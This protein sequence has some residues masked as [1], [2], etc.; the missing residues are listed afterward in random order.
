MIEIGGFVEDLGGIGEDEEA[1]SEAFGDPEELEGVGVEVEAGPFAEVGG[2]WAEVY[3]DVPDMAGED[4]DELSL[5]L[6]ELIME[7]AEDAFGGERLVILKKLGGKTGGREGGLVVNFCKPA[8]TI[9]ETVG[10]N[11]FYVRKRCG[12]N[13]HPNSL[14]GER[15]RVPQWANQ[16]P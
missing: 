16:Y 12:L 10:F 2:A 1:V 4:A 11:E 8:A 13:L 15:S 9:S 14:S 3:S 6:S 5:G 7:A